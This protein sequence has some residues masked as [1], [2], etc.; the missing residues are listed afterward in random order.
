MKRLGRVG[1]FLK[2]GVGGTGYGVGGCLPSEGHHF[3]DVGKV[4]GTGGGEC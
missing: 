4:G 3:V 2:M 1:K